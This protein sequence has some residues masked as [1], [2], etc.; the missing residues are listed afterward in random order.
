MK[1]VAPRGKAVAIEEIGGN[2]ASWGLSQVPLICRK[3]QMK[4]EETV[5]ALRMWTYHAAGIHARSVEGAR[6]A[7]PHMPDS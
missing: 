1:T 2:K 5:D 7:V 6:T 4:L 3:V